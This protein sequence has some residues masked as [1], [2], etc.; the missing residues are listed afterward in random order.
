MSEACIFITD[1]IRWTI[2]SCEG[3]RKPPE[4][5]EAWHTQ[6]LRKPAPTVTAEISGWCASLGERLRLRTKETQGPEEGNSSQDRFFLVE[7]VCMLEL[8][9]RHSG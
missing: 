4:E 2:N 7:K 5:T 9:Q 3:N 6:L 8:D 1:L